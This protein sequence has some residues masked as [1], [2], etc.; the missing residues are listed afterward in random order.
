MLSCRKS[1]QFEDALSFSPAWIS[2]AKWAA[3][4]KVVPW[5]RTVLVCLPGSS[6]GVLATP[7]KSRGHDAS[8]HTS[9]T[10]VPG[11]KQPE[12]AN[13]T[14]SEDTELGPS[15]RG[16]SQESPRISSKLQVGV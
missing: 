7:G 2:R 14:L 5:L 1:W 10:T 4:G 3:A 12:P 13:E 6:L 8:T 16:G 11:M 9:W 15:P